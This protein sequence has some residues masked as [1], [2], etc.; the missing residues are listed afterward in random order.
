MPQDSGM[1]PQGT[2]AVP[3]GIAHRYRH[4][5]CYLCQYIC[6]SVADVNVL[7]SDES[8]DC[9]G[10]HACIAYVLLLSLIYKY[11]HIQMYSFL[12]LE[13]ISFIILNSD[14]HIYSILYYCL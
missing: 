6:L 2:K 12:Y 5:V 3:Q 10:L 13:V 11:K 1:V 4:P 8:A 9:L 14:I 7:D